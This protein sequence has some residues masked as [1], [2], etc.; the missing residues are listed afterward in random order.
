MDTITVRGART[1]NLKNIDLD[2]PRDS[3]IVITGLSGSGKSSLAFDT[4]YAEG[5]RRYVESLSAYARQFLSMMEKPDVDH[6]EGLS[7]AISIEQKSTSHNPRS[8]VGTITEIYDYLRLLFARTG[9][10]RCPEHHLPLEAQTVSQMVDQ[11]LALPEGTKLMLLAPVVRDRKGEHL[12]VFSELRAQGFIRARIDGIVTD[13]D[14]PPELDKKKK[15]TIEVVV[16]RFKV[17]EDLQLRLA[18]SFETALELTDGLAAVSFMDGEQHDIVY[19]ARFACPS[20]GYSINELEP[21]MFSFNNPAGACPSC[22]GLG[23]KQ[24]FDEDRIVQHPEL[25]LAEGAIRGWD[26]RSVYYFHLLKSLAAHFGFDIDTAFDDLTAE[27]QTI[28]LHG[29]GEEQI[30]FSYVNDRGDVYK[31]RHRFEGIIPNF[32]RRFRETESQSVREELSKYLSTQ[33]CPGCK[34]TRLRQESRHVFIED[35]TLPDLVRLPVERALAYFEQLSLPGQKGEIAEKILKEICDRL[36]FLV[37]VGLNYLT[38]DRSADTLSGGEAQR[39]RLASQ[40]G[41]GLVGVMYILD[42]PSI[43]LHQ[44]DNERLLNTLTRLRDLGNTVIVVEHDEDAIRTADHVI[45]IGPGAGVHGGEI[46]AQGTPA[47]IMD[48]E[49][50]VTGQYLNGTKAIAIPE[51]RTRADKNKRIKLTGCS[52]NNLKNVTLEIPVGLMT[53]V[54]GVSGSGKSTLIN[55]TLYP[56]AAQVLNSATTL[57]ASKHKKIS[58]LNHFDKCIDIDQSPIGRTPRS[59]PA[60]YTGIF[61]AIRELFAGTQEARSRGYKPGRFS[62]N[63]KGGRCE[64]CQGDGVIKVEMHFLPD[65]YVPCDVCKGKR[66]NRETLDVKYKGKNIHEVLEMTVEEALEY[67]EPIPAVKR[68]LQTL[69]DV[70]LSYIHLGQNATTLSG[71]EAQRVKLAKELS[72]R[73]TGKTL[74]I[75]DEPTTGLHFHDIEQLLAVLHRLR[76][77]GNTVV[78]IEHNLDVIK[79]ADWIVDLGPEGGDG[80]GQIIA[81]GPPEVVAEST[82]SHTGRFLKPMLK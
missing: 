61:T 28:I 73:D 10:P 41:A 47:Q 15:H 70:G 48:H 39:I 11:V 66:Y 36:S 23:V 67:F 25:T 44:R 17:R 72:K 78:V 46:I 19:S 79:T 68:K 82:A 33:H 52:G 55:N 57:T 65:I 6:I 14:N 59:N 31:K 37:N 13:L 24:F 75:L 40:I 50:S 53:C 49:K 54:T 12:H 29:S 2:M 16:D 63:V 45:D 34:G 3:L 8:T 35:E 80:G 1:H 69:M 43:G 60:T 38:L 26:R 22:D 81:G 77:R 4:L 32:E 21:R 56:I 42:E 9:T 27:Q 58:G 30:D 62:F 76:D 51:K 7:P 18:E 74:Y 64:A 5:Q 20:C 71:G